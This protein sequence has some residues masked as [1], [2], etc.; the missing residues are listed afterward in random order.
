MLLHSILH[1]RIQLQALQRLVGFMFY[2]YRGTLTPIYFP[3]MIEVYCL[4]RFQLFP[5]RT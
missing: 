4:E 3:A 1:L 5:V 2:R